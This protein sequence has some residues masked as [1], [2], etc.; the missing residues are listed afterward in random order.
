MMTAQRARTQVIVVATLWLLIGSYALWA[1][2]VQSSWGFY[3]VL[4]LP[5]YVLG[6]F[7]FGWLLSRRHGLALSRA[8]FSLT[9]MAAALL[10]AIVFVVVSLWVSSV[11]PV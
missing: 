7:F 4:S 2:G 11:L 3:V 6:E 5:G 9:R 10:V 8:K 1:T